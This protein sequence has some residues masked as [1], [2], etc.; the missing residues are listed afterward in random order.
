MIYGMRKQQSLKRLIPITALR[1]LY[2]LLRDF[3]KEEFHL[4]MAKEFCRKPKQL[5]ELITKSRKHFELYDNQGEGFHDRGNDGSLTA[6]R[7]NS[8]KLADKFLQQLAAKS[9]SFASALQRYEFVYIDYDISPYRTTG[10]QFEN[11]TSGRSSGTGGMDI[12]LSNKRDQTPIVGETKADTDVNPFLGL[13]QSLMYAVELSTPSQRIRLCQFY[14]ERFAASS[15]DQGID[16]Y[17]FLLRYAQDAR[18]QEFLSLTNQLSAKLIEMKN[19]KT[20]VRRIVALES[21]MEGNVLNN[22]TLAFAHGA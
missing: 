11:G 6:D 14:N 8:Q 7:L 9:V 10:S 22:F 5:A 15:P 12:L 2:Q 3:P 1:H 17:L 16:I 18:S 13:I 19:M 4:A 20:M 21:P